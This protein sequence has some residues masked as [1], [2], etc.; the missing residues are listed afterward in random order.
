MRL[1]TLSDDHGRIHEH[2]LPNRLAP[3]SRAMGAVCW[4]W[5]DGYQPSWTTMMDKA[6]DLNQ[7]HTLC[8]RTDR[9]DAGDGMSVTSAEILA[10]HNEGH[11][12]ASHTVSHPGLAGLTTSTLVAELEDSK[13]ALEAIVGVGNVTTFVYPYGATDAASHRACW[14]RY[15]R[16][17]DYKA[18]AATSVEDRLHTFV[19]PRTQVRTFAQG[20]QLIDLARRQPIVVNLAGH[21]PGGTFSDGVT[22]D[23]L[24]LQDALDL[25]QYCYDMGVPCLTSAEAYP[26]AS[27]LMNPSFEDD[28]DGWRSSG[29]GITSPTVTPDT[30][31]DGSKALQV[32]PPTTG[33]AGVRQL[34][35]VVPGRSYTLSGRVRIT[36]GTIAAGSVKARIVGQ[37]YE[38]P[39]SA[40]GLDV[41]T[42][43]A[44]S[45]NPAGATWERF[46]IDAVIP[47]GTRFADVQCRVWDQ[48]GLTAQFDHLHFGPTELGA[49]G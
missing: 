9:I 1:P 29:S 21:N 41:G 25:M 23:P 37:G 38:G 15:D 13:A 43:L 46:E 6:R 26:G 35:P 44:E 22:P 27:A 17:L 45:A 47:Q 16:V 20:R 12:T 2:L 42:M 19:V 14:G 10:W 7:K 18:A 32:A 5:D 11:E 40:D 28:T 33:G 39:L 49:F 3:A 36:G 34:V 8:Y 31:V 24:S 30:A 4:S 48:T